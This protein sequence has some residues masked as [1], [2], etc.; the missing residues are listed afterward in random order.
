MEQ[1]AVRV[2]EGQEKEIS[3]QWE[4]IEQSG[5]GMEV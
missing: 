5:G 2:N 4:E 1:R 3:K